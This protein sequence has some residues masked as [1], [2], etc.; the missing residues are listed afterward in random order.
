MTQEWLNSF[1]EKLD[2]HHAWPDL[3][4]FKF[5][6]PKGKEEEVKKLFPRHQPSHR[7]SKNG[8]YISVTVQSMM[9]SAEDIIEIYVRA[10]AI[11]GLIAL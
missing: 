3:Y 7:A 4:I 8:K 1:R 5:I 9:A 10:S 6:V 2:R 11:P